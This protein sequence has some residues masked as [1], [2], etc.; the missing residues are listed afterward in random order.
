MLQPLTSIAKDR[1]CT[2]S[3]FSIEFLY[4]RR[5]S[6]L[7][8]T[9]VN[10]SAS[11]PDAEIATQPGKK[12]RI[13]LAFSFS[14]GAG[15]GSKGLQNDF[16]TEEIAD[17]PEPR[18]SIWQT[19]RCDFEIIFERDPAARHWLEVLCCYPGLH[20][21]ALHRFA[22]WL[23]DRSV[24]FIPRAISHFARFLTGIEIHPGATLGKGVF[25]DHG[26]GVVIGETA[27]VGDYTLIYQGVTLGGTGK[28]MGKRHPTLGNS[29]I[30]GAGAKVLGNIT[31][32]D[33]VRIG[34]G[35]IVLQNVPADCT[36]V[37][38]PGR[39]VSR[40][41]RGCPLEHA[42]LPDVQ[43]MAIQTLLDRIEKLEQQIQNFQK[44]GGINDG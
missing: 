35:S 33:N 16:Y 13:P 29:A 9:E 34:A 5:K 32:G 20:A 8:Q 42:Q 21:I 14:G 41:G 26:M 31:I 6:R 24:F 36:V 2:F 10:P 3:I 38:V 23:Y 27:I 7:S 19:L 12:T 1:V 11:L 17:R 25:I 39:I 15:G 40:S 4:R 37:G 28:E 22:R 30:V 43:A 44:K 18:L